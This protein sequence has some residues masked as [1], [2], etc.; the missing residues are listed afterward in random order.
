MWH[1]VN[2]AIRQYCITS[3]PLCHKFGNISIFRCN[4]TVWEVLNCSFHQSF[5]GIPLRNIILHPRNSGLHFTFREILFNSSFADIWLMCTCTCWLTV[6]VVGELLYGLLLLFVLVDEF[7]FGSML[8]LAIQ[9]LL[10]VLPLLV[11]V[12]V[13][14][15]LFGVLHCR[16]SLISFS[17]HQFINLIIFSWSLWFSI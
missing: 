3:L 15:L 4:E 16:S 6:F 10:E 11:L 12:L 8:V 7:S 1:I 17:C 13:Y 5:Q 14:A 2:I 9:L